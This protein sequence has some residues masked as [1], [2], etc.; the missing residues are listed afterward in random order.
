MSNQSNKTIVYIISAASLLFVGALA[1]NKFL[2][3]DN[4][5]VINVPELTKT[6]SNP[7]DTKKSKNETPIDTYDIKFDTSK[8]VD[9]RTLSY[10]ERNKILSDNMTKRI[11]FQTPEEVVDVIN[12][13]KSQGNIEKVNEYTEFLKQRFPEFIFIDE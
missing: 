8:K 7:V 11:K 9:L 5:E 10:E 12:I 3:V 2:K 1:Y 4:S 6:N 13:F